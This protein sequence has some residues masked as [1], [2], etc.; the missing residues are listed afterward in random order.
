MGGPVQIDFMRETA[1][2]DHRQIS[3]SGWLV[4]F[5]QGVARLWAGQWSHQ[6]A[7]RKIAHHK[8]LVGRT[9]RRRYFRWQVGKA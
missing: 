4:V 9:R 8:A 3:L 7:V 6:A 2:R 5:F 1:S